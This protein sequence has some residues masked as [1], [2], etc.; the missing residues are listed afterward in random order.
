MTIT[1]LVSTF[2][3]YVHSYDE[4]PVDRPTIHLF[5]VLHSSFY[6]DS[7]PISHVGSKHEDPATVLKDTVAERTY[8][9]LMSSTQQDDSSLSE[10]TWEFLKKRALVSRILASEQ[11]VDRRLSEDSENG[12]FVLQIN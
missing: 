6:I 9:N 4:L 7:D 5:L 2:S 10:D 11:T 1:V 12:N 8:V 3:S